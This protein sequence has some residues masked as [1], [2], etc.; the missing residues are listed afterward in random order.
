MPGA[1]YVA[2]ARIDPS[3]QDLAERIAVHRSRRPPSWTTT[4][5]TEAATLPRA[6]R[7]TEGTVLVDS[8]G[9]WVAASPDLTI[10][11]DELVRALLERDGDTILVSD[12]VGL[13]VHPSSDEGRHFRDVLGE[14]NQAVAAVAG[15]VLLAVAGR[16]LALP[17]LEAP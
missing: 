8:L 7:G 2:T 13:G 6:L 5:V 3:D 11:P 1:T 9:T 14:L 12:E 10:D 15:D 4:E 17:P 16:V